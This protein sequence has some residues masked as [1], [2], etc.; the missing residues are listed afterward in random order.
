MEGTLNVCLMTAAM[1]TLGQC[2]TKYIPGIS[3]DVRHFKKCVSSI[4]TGDIT[5]NNQDKNSLLELS[6]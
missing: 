1:T 2:Y 3:K 4:S 5:V 6:V